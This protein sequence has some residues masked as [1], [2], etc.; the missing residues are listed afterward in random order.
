MKFYERKTSW[1]SVF[2]NKNLLLLR[3]RW[4]FKTVK[5][6]TI[7]ILRLSSPGKKIALRLSSRS[8]TPVQSTRILSLRTTTVR[9]TLSVF[10]VNTFYYFLFYSVSMER[11][12][13]HNISSVFLLRIDEID[14]SKRTSTTE[15]Q[16]TVVFWVYKWSHDGNKK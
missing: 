9:A 7:Q 2:V 11:K 10:A 14:F 16:N 5:N 13:L 15:T 3:R 12:I 1:V 6:R 4:W 8:R